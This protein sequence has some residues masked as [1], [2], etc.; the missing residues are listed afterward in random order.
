M[1]T[2]IATTKAIQEIA[3]FKCESVTLDKD[4]V[5]TA[6]DIRKGKTHEE[7]ELMALKCLNIYHAEINM[8]PFGIG[9]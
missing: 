7:K 3:V 6:R 2:A 8:G 1:N 9:G 5:N 4:A